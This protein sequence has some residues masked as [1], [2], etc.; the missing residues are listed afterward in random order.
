MLSR[1]ATPH[2]PLLVDMKLPF[3]KDSVGTVQEGE[4]D[5]LAE[6]AGRTGLLLRECLCLVKIR[7][8]SCCLIGMR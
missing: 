8:G 3:L 6:L 4:S 1:C 7:F 5:G 2:R